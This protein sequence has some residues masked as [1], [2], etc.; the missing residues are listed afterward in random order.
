MSIRAAWISDRKIAKWRKL[1]R[2]EWKRNQR[3]PQVAG[4]LV[5]SGWTMPIDFGG[6]NLF[7]MEII[8]NNLDYSSRFIGESVKFAL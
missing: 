5:I 1:S 4:N 8:T 7:L 2:V 6:Y 3:E